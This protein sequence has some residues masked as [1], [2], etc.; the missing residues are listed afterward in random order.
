MRGNYITDGRPR[1]LRLYLPDLAPTIEPVARASQEA[2]AY[3]RRLGQLLADIRTALG[4]T[5]AEAAERVGVAEDT[6]G[7]WEGA[8][9]VPKADDLAKVADVYE[10]S[11]EL[12]LLLLSPLE[13]SVAPVLLLLGDRV[14]AG[15]RMGL[16]RRGR[17]R[18]AERAH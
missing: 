16:T 3:R 7:R 2:L 10:L 14:Q 4:L 6:I 8:L 15:F 18:G 5:Q 13:E 12:R 1:Q 17:K 9:T 11:A